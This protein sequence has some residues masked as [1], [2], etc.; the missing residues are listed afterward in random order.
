[1]YIYKASGESPWCRK[2][3]NANSDCERLVN[4]SSTCKETENLQ[5]N[6]TPN[7][8]GNGNGNENISNAPPTVDRRRIT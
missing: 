1:M 5:L 3:R 7:A 8:Y 2:V 4:N 6:V